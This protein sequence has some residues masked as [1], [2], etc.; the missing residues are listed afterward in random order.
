MKNRVKKTADGRM[1]L[2]LLSYSGAAGLLPVCRLLSVLLCV[3]LAFLLQETG[4]L[5]AEGYD[6]VAGKSSMGDTNEELAPYGM[7]PVSGNMIED[8]EYVVGTECSS[9][10]FRIEEARLTVKDGKMTALLRMYS[11]SYLLVYPGTAEEA[12][13]ADYE[14]YIPSVEIDDYDTFTVPVEALDTELELAAFSKRKKAW[15][16]RKILFHA[17]DI[18]SDCLRFSYPDYDRISEAMASFDAENN[19]EDRIT[20]SQTGSR[21][22]AGTDSKTDS[23]AAAG[24]DSK[25][26]SQAAGTDEKTQDPQAVRIDMPDGDYSIEVNLM[27][28]S[29]RASVTTPTWMYVQGG[30]GYARLLWSSPHYDYMI[31]DGRTYYNETKDGG[32]SS[33]TIPIT[34]TDMPV[35]IIADTTAMG[36]PVE[37][38]YTLTFYEETIGSRS[39]VPQEGALR[40]LAAAALF[41]VA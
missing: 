40:V 39:R 5:A 35:D 14:D 37:I 13:A 7:T 11:S 15:Y 4:V 30:K 16:P 31:L 28:G 9:S 41:I 10:F 1:C 38:A 3:M 19:A 20:D 27:G 32:N 33:F 29:G 8:G 23:Q 18:P 22:A 21:A 26:D 34:A 24:T 25:T 36:D 2:P 12:A 17:S 6:K